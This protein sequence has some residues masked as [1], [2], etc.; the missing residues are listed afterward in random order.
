MN[1]K[2]AVAEGYSSTTFENEEIRDVNEVIMEVQ[3]GKY[4]VIS[5]IY[6]K[7]DDRTLAREGVVL[8]EVRARKL[9]REILEGLKKKKSSPYYT[10]KVNKEL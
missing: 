9:K 1:K 5:P 2:G 7:S 3:G 10:T 4:E 8:S 6:R